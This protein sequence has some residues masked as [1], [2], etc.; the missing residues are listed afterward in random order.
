MEKR[1]RRRYL[2]PGFSDIRIMSGTVLNGSKVSS[3][4]EQGAKP[5]VPVEDNNEE[6]IWE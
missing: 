5:S 4:D 1:A 6:T 3:G 2:K